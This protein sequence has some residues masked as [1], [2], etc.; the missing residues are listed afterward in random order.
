MKNRLSI[1]LFLGVALGAFGQ[2]QNDS[3]KNSDV[4]IKKEYEPRISD[5]FK[6]SDNPKLLDTNITIDKDVP[7]SVRTKRVETS[8]EPKPIK[9]A[10]MKGEPLNKLYKAYALFGLGNYLTTRG[11]LVINNTR[12]RKLDY[13]F[14]A[15]HHGSRGNVKDR[16]YSGFTDN[17]FSL[18]GQKFFYNKIVSGNL[19]YDL[20][21]L[22]YYGFNPDDINS[23]AVTDDSLSKGNIAQNFQNI[24]PTLRFKTYYK[25][26]NKYNLD[27]IV[28]YAHYWDKQNSKEDN[29]YA[30]GTIDRYFNTEF[31]QLTAWVDVNSFKFDR[32]GTNKK[33]NSTL[34]GL[35]PSV[36]TG[37]DKWKLR[38][39][40]EIVMSSGSKQD[41]FF[42]P[43]L[44][45]KYDLVKDILI[46]Y[47]GVNGSV[48]RNSYKNLTRVN[49]FIISNPNTGVENTKYNVYG[50][51]R[52]EIATHLSFNAF[53]SFKQVED[54]AL[55]LN[56][57][58]SVGGFEIANRFNVRYDD[59]TVTN[60][61]AE[62][63]YQKGKKI[64]VL[65]KG[66]YFIYNTK[67]EKAAWNMP[68]YKLSLNGKYNIGEK[69][70]ITADVFV[71]G[72][73]TAYT[74]LAEGNESFGNGIYGKTLKPLFDLNLGV[75]YFFNPNWTAFIRTYNLANSRY[76]IYNE[77]YQQGATVLIGTSYKF[78]GSKKRVK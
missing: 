31:A 10:K 29:F 54:M 47:A 19:D 61:G 16:G 6:L 65:F 45:I 40:G 48:K 67:N 26:S 20:N 73:R 44:Y 27:A 76:A 69:I 59:V 24:E 74:W 30:S 3:L 72:E 25:D 21:S 8:F 4:I 1:V 46:P 70:R 12:S 32:S 60:L 71:I 56:R 11:E 14:K 78:W 5:A 58:D 18:Y 39:G 68:D 17:N 41:F 38:V 50:G 52:G 49:P 33:E 2:T 53:G 43:D 34:F 64:S 62:I 13:G 75:E 66:E 22:H 7:Y 9:P 77:Y 37:K 42:Y 55:F 51:I 36:V 15:W 57:K 28:R 35:K 63:G 23:T